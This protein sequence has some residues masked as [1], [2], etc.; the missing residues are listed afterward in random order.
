MGR[1]LGIVSPD[2]I[3]FDRYLLSAPASLS[4]LD[5]SVMQPDGWGA[6]VYDV[7]SGGWRVE[8]RALRGAE[9]Q[10]SRSEDD[11]FGAVAH[12][13]RGTVLVGSIRART[14]TAAASLAAPPFRRGP[15]VFAHDGAIDDIEQVRRGVSASRLRECETQADGELL[16]AYILT[17][18]DRGGVTAAV[19]ISDLDAVVR[20]AVGE[21][22]ASRI[23]AVSF[24]LSNG[25]ALYAHR[26][27]RSLYLLERTGPIRLAAIAS[28]PL[29][30]EPWL[31]LG[32]NTLL[33]CEQG[34]SLELAM[35]RGT[36]P[37]AP[38]SDVELPF[39]D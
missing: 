23:G 25:A 18:L 1:L 2:L 11:S 3:A 13:L 19:A 28:E 36:D 24:L 7:G 16:F 5:L 15:W 32:N 31:G 29:T 39:T 33:R 37:R 21:I 12:R 17:F 10:V 26:C 35:L 8:K 4:G 9:G 38:I 30:D 34:T 22:A 6:A 20:D 14:V 27:G